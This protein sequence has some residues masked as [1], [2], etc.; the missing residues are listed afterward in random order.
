M[1]LWDMHE[2]DI[3]CTKWIKG[4]KTFKFILVLPNLTF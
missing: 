1:F 3:I 4:N 2:T